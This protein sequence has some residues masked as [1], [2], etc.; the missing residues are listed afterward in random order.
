MD[1]YDQPATDTQQDFKVTTY[2]QMT[3]A[4]L[5]EAIEIAAKY[6]RMDESPNVHTVSW[7]MNAH[8]ESLLAIQKARA[9]AR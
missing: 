6:A 3:N 9:E 5:A 2:Q 8:L 1:P 7:K 4:E